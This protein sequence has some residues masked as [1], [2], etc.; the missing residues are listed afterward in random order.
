VPLQAIK[1]SSSVIKYLVWNLRGLL[2]L[3]YDAGNFDRIWPACGQY[4]IP[5][6]E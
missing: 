6:T 4:E 3:V 1:T 5:Y 2:N